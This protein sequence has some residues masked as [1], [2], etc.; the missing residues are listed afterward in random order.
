MSWQY[1][2]PEQAG[3]KIPAR[4]IESSFCNGFQ[5]ALRGRQI[6]R[7][8][9]LR[10]SYREGYRAGKLYLRELR[11][12]QGILEFPFKAHMKASCRGELRRS[13]RRLSQ[14]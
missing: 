7:V 13:Q 9:Q 2:T 14:R 12:A 8:E 1:P 10:L 11:R 6:T 3:I 5:H 4:L